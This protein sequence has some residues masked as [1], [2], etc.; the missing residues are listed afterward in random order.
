MWLTALVAMSV[1]WWMDSRRYEW[2]I[3]SAQMRKDYYNLMSELAR[4][5]AQKAIDKQE[6][7]SDALQRAEEKAAAVEPKPGN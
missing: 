6:Q 1:G 5:E 7:L 2:S 3:K 4:S